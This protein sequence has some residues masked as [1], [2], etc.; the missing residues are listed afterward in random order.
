V[1]TQ[2]PEGKIPVDAAPEQLKGSQTPAFGGLGGVTVPGPLS[3]QVSSLLQQPGS[4]SEKPE[5]L[6]LDLSS[7][8]VL[9]KRWNRPG[10]VI[11]FD[12]YTGKA[13]TKTVK[14]FAELARTSGAGTPRP[15]YVNI[16]ELTDGSGSVALV[17]ARYMG[18]N[19]LEVTW[20][21]GAEIF[22]ID[23]APLLM[24]RPFH[25]PNQT[26]A[27]VPAEFTTLKGV[28]PCMVLHFKDAAFFAIEPGPPRKRKTSGSGETAP[29]NQGGEASVTKPEEPA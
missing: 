6:P 27:H 29:A 3:G 7:V 24:L 25:I 23:L 20:S 5:A 2:E 18:A 17:P 9:R 16:H 21:K 8:T 10:L 13:T 12:G 4:D 15:D 22:S 19:S 11:R 26:R 28:G 14:P 1:S